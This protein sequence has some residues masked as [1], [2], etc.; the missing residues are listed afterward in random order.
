MPVSGADGDFKVCPRLWWHLYTM[1]AVV[2]GYFLPFAYGPPHPP[3]HQETGYAYADVGRSRRAAWGVSD[4]ER[5]V[6]FDF[7]RD[8]INAV[9]ATFPHDGFPG[10]YSKWGSRTI[11]RC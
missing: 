1:R 6:A 4:K 3:T 11:G 7:D 9:A 8:T 2:D 5:H 10:R